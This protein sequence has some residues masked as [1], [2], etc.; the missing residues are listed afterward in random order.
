MRKLW[1]WTKEHISGDIRK[2]RMVFLCLH[3]IMWAAI[4]F[5]L[6]ILYGVF[7]GFSDKWLEYT[8]IAMGY[9]AIYFGF[10][11]GALIL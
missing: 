10:F 3:T 6:C 5:L 9:P 11:G 4:P 7:V 1:N 2:K 8:I